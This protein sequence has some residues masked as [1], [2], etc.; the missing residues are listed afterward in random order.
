MTTM[1]NEPAACHGCS[2]R[3][4]IADDIPCASCG[5]SGLLA[6]E[7]AR[8]PRARFITTICGTTY[9]CA[10]AGQLGALIGAWLQSSRDIGPNV[11]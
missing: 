4:R 10:D 6:D 8:H 3:G 7:Q 1:P 11:H 9:Y 5:G 2:G